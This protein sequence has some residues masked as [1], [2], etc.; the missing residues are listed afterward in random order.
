VETSSIDLKL[1]HKVVN[2]LSSYCNIIFGNLT[3]GHKVRPLWIDDGTRHPVLSGKWR[4][5]IAVAARYAHRS[6]PG[7][8]VWGR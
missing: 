7:S 4:R 3:E 6:T 8:G 5:L 2:G 1:Q